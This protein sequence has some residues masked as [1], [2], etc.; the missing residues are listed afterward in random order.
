MRAVAEK[1]AEKCSPKGHL[2]VEGRFRLTWRCE[3]GM[4]KDGAPTPSAFIANLRA[5]MPLARKLKLIARNM[6]IKIVHVQSCCGHPGE[7]GC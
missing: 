5:P 1:T 2:L 4:C 3:T 6:T 7:P